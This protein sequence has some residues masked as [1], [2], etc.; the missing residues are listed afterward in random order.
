ME[1][2][3]NRLQAVGIFKMC[4]GS[5]TVMIIV[6]FPGHMRVMVLAG[7]ESGVVRIQTSSDICVGWYTSEVF[8]ICSAHHEVIPARFFVYKAE[9]HDGGFANGWK[10]VGMLQ[11]C[12]FAV[13]L[14]S[15][16]F[17]CLFYCSFMI[18]YYLMIG[19]G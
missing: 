2:W 9:V 12:P 18:F 13:T 17:K 16:I 7:V 3:W 5:F 19:S 8:L 11:N 6:A 4:S 10:G 1:V 15:S 14:P